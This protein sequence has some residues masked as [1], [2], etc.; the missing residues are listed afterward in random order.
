LV[1]VVVAALR[2]QNGLLAIEQPELH[3]HPAIQ[4]A[5]GDLFIRAVRPDSG[6]LDASKTML[7]E[8]HSEHI[9]LRLLRRIRETSEGALPPDVDPLLPK[10]LAVIYVEGDENGVRFDTL[11]VDSEGEF[12]DRWPKGFFGERGKELF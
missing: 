5:I 2:P 4:V 12:V 6:Q 10:D 1:P 8:T 7:I 11:R 9:M 3:V